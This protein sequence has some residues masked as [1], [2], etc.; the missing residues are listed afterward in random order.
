HVLAGNWSVLPFVRTC[1]HTRVC[2]T[3]LS[4]VAWSHLNANFVRL[5]LRLWTKSSV[6]S[7]VFSRPHLLAFPGCTFCRGTFDGW[8]F[9]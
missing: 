5:S 9:L 2:K 4:G 7:S 3:L 1:V 6:W 8:V